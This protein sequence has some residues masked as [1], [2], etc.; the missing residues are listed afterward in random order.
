MSDL[1]IRLNL[2]EYFLLLTLA[3]PHARILQGLQWEKWDWMT[4]TFTP[5]KI[6][7]TAVRVSICP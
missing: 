6:L 4:D 5:F 3:Q 1:P 2:P 7:A